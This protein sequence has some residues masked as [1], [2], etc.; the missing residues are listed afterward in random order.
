M[1]HF[2]FLAFFPSLSS[3]LS[4]IQYAHYGSVTRDKMSAGKD[5]HEVKLKR[6][7]QLSWKQEEALKDVGEHLVFHPGPPLTSCITQSVV[8]LMRV[9]VVCCLNL[10]KL[11]L[12][13]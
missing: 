3:L 7:F 8:C 4:Y 11:L 12:T 6:T 2:S 5:V 1:K 10:K 9:L 13:I